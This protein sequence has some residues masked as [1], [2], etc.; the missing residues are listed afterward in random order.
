MIYELFNQGHVQA[1]EYTTF[2]D[3]QVTVWACVT[4]HFQKYLRAVSSEVAHEI[5]PVFITWD[6]LG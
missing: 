5:K 4:P 6:F 2:G 1:G 3:I